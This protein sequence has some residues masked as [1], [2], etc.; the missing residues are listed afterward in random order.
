M[1]T[2]KVHLPKK[3]KTSGTGWNYIIRRRGALRFYRLIF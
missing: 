2:V 1:Q 3:E